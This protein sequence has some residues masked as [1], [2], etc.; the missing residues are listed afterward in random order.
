LFYSHDGRRPV[1]YD[2]SVKDRYGHHHG[3]TRMLHLGDDYF[4]SLSWQTDIARYHHWFRFSVLP[5]DELHEAGSFYVYSHTGCIVSLNA[6]SDLDISG[7]KANFSNSRY[8]FPVGTSYFNDYL[9]VDLD[10]KYSET[11]KDQHDYLVDVK[12]FRHIRGTLNSKYDA[13]IPQYNKNVHFS[14]MSYNVWNFNSLPDGNAR[15]YSERMD[16]LKTVCVG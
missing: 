11:S 13:F 9:T 1:L 5:E 8:L 4:L 6:S 16:R 12:S 14:V 10:S 7:G 15:S 2:D 3:V